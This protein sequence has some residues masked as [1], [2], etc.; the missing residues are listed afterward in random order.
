MKARRV[1]EKTKQFQFYP[2]LILL[3]SFLLSILNLNIVAFDS[4]MSLHL[5]RSFEW[6]SL[7]PSSWRGPEVADFSFRI[8]G[9]IYYWFL[10]TLWTVTQSVEGLLFSTVLFSYFCFYL[11]LRQ[12]KK[13][14]SLTATALWT[15]I[16]FFTPLFFI[17]IR[18]LENEALAN[19]FCSLI[20][21]TALKF[22]TDGKSKWIWFSSGLTLVGTQIHMAVLFPYLSFWAMILFRQDLFKGKYKF[23]AIS[24]FCI[25]WFFLGLSTWPLLKSFL[26][27]T[28]PL[29]YLIVAIYTRFLDHKN[30]FLRPVFLGAAVFI[31]ATSGYVT[32]KNY[33]TQFQL[34]R[35]LDLDQDD[36]EMTLKLKKFIYSMG[37]PSDTD[38]FAFMH[39]RAINRMRR[40]EMNSSQTQPYFGLYQSLFQQKVTYDIS[41]KDKAPNSSWLFQLRNSKEMNL[42]P[43]SPFLMTEIKPYALP[44]KTVIKYLNE[45]S[46]G[47]EKIRWNNSSLILPFA[48]LSY[49][50]ETKVV[51]FEFELNSKAEK[52]LNLLVDADE[53]YKIL[54]VKINSKVQSFL[55]HY[56]GN[57]LQQSQ[58]I[59]KIPDRIEQAKVV[60]EVRVLTDEVP[61]LSRVD[62]FTSGYLLASE[63]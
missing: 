13:S 54:Q 61:N 39:G 37:T 21:L 26:H 35:V 41:L 52:Y 2:E 36:S 33:E 51:R 9:P 3:A 10:S 42:N 7:S 31:S 18:R 30:S 43:Q 27:L 15:L 16:F 38:P 8:I 17:S 53:K 48:F 34:G 22:Q 4:E 29:S 46:Q 40:D 55:E 45:K 12:L 6:L 23:S 20:F 50:V 5:T 24:F 58:Y 11:L 49:P 14:E 19:A 47:L 1:L 56:P 59:Y 63:F 28:L 32:L 44:Q 60:I 25:V 62:I 57:S